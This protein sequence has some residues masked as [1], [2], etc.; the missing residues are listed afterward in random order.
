MFE[1]TL[2]T[3]IEI[4][5]PALRVW[6][7]LADLDAYHTWNPM[8]R[9][10][11]GELRPG[12]R[13]RLLFHPA[14]TGARVFRPV[15]LTVEPGRELRWEGRP[16]VPKI[17][18]SEHVFILKKNGGN[19]TLLVHDMVFRGLLAPLAVKKAGRMIREQFEGMNRALKNRAESRDVP[20]PDAR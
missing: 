16:C 4:Q 14:G 15:L 6:E 7:I 18:E 10:A 9:E 1:S 17:I 19:G 12:E 20:H 13:L 2:C 11:S 3:A 5:A 8:I